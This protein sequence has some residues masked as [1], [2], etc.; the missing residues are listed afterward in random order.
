MNPYFRFG[1]M[2]VVLS[3]ACLGLN[4]QFKEIKAAPFSAFTARQKI[5]ALL[6]N[7]NPENRDQTV[8]TIS[9][10]L[11]WYRDVLDGE[12]IERWKSEDRANLP[13]V[14][15][16]LADAKVAREVMEFSWSVD[17]PAAFTLAYA[18]MLG[19][20]MA[21]YAESAKPFLDGLFVAPPPQLSPSE[22]EAVCR[23]LLDMPDIG[24][25]RKNALQILPRYRLTVD[26]LL[27]QDAAGADQ[28]QMYRALRWRADLGLD[29]PAPNTSKL[30]TR[31]ERPGSS[32][33]LPAAPSDSQ[34]PHLV[35]R[36]PSADTYT[37]P[38]SGT[39]ESQGEPIP[40]N[41]EYV[42]RNIPPGKLVLD[43][44][45]KHWEARL[46]P[47]EGQA[48]VLVLRNIGKGPQKRCVVHWTLAP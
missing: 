21:R 12:L 22:A 29:P 9:D 41:A 10:W 39:F 5:R 11:K 20:L 23:V 2:A 30:K 24:A 26:R 45:T 40:Q 15:A 37:G 46:A 44:D 7:V 43:F 35:L 28:E 16:P 14:M 34:R 42:F 27:K 4:A 32:I 18:P 6:Q 17:R 38:T 3:V 13:L 1:G 19:D 33:Q 31:N 36:Q 8:A 25:W 47:G 48:Q